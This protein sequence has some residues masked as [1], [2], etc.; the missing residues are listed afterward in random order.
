MLDGPGNMGLPLVRCLATGA[1]LC[2]IDSFFG[3]CESMAVADDETF[4]GCDAVRGLSC[5]RSYLK[6]EIRNLY[7]PSNDLTNR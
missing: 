4:R 6:V 1:F 7:E 5:M 3:R 2:G